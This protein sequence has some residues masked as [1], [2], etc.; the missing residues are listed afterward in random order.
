MDSIV[1]HYNYVI[2]PS[3][4]KLRGFGIVEAE[5]AQKYLYELK[6]FLDHTDKFYN[7]LP[8][9]NRCS[10]AHQKVHKQTWK[11]LRYISACYLNAFIAFGKEPARQARFPGF[12]STQLSERDLTL[13]DYARSQFKYGKCNPLTRAL[14]QLSQRQGLF[15]VL[16]TGLSALVTLFVLP[17]FSFTVSPSSLWT[18]GSVIVA[19]LFTYF[20]L[21]KFV[22]RHYETKIIPQRA[23]N[24]TLIQDIL[25]LDETEFDCIFE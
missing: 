18:I 19:N 8:P 3:Y 2:Y 13:L 16:F 21:Q 10:P 12:I 15:T 20:L 14:L 25:T 7:S 1:H 9:F 23:S 6:D 4:A 22:T 24:K 17:V 5:N 11:S